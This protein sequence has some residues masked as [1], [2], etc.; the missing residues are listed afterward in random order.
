MTQEKIQ[1][2]E[3]RITKIKVELAK[4]GD[5]RPGSLTKQYRDKEKRNG[6]YYQLSYTHE[7][8][9]HTN[10]VRQECVD[11]VRQQIKNYKRFKELTIEWVALGIEHSKLS[12]KKEKTEKKK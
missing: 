8:K 1:E 6:K 12:M 5:M 11:K 10:Y 2:I 3:K 7:M 4:I 9:S